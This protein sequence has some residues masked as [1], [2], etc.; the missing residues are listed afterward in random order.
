MLRRLHFVNAP[1]IIVQGKPRPYHLLNFEGVREHAVQ[2]V[3]LK[4]TDFMPP[5]LPEP[6]YGEF[7]REP[8]LTEDEKL[9]LHDWLDS[10]AMDGDAADLPEPPTWTSGWQLRPPDSVL[11][12]PVSTL[13]SSEGGLFRNFGPPWTGTLGEDRWTAPLNPKRT[14]HARLGI[15][16][17][18]RI[19]VQ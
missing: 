14:H 4:R 2:T 1:R 17:Y 10:G 8:R 15:D 19:H 16:H 7:I 6:G 5:W 18:R 3:E 11:E 13:S 9:L 12:S